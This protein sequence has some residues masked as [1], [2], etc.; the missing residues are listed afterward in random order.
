MPRNVN[1]NSRGDKAP[2]DYVFHYKLD[3]EP[4]E[5]PV[6]HHRPTEALRE[7]L[8]SILDIVIPLDNGKDIKVDGFRWLTDR[9]KLYQLLPR[10]TGSSSSPD[11][12]PGKH[13][14]ASEARLKTVY[15]NA[16]NA[17]FYEPRINLIKEM[18]E[19]L[20]TLIEF[21]QPGQ[22]VEVDGFRD[23]KSSRIIP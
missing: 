7:I 8:Q 10:N 1:P 21:E 15:Q 18:I 22:K 4:E 12:H 14:P 6:Y 11:L 2:R 19:S 5:T 23:W 3:T 20:L 17:A 9:E 13:T 16:S